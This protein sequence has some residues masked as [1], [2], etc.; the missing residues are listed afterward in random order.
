VILRDAA[1]IRREGD[2]LTGYDVGQ[3]QTYPS[4][5]HQEEEKGLPGIDP[6]LAGRE[7]ISP[8]GGEPPGRPAAG[9]SR[10]RKAGR[11]RKKRSHAGWRRP[12]VLVGIFAG[13]SS[14]LA[15]ALLAAAPGTGTNSHIDQHA[16]ALPS[17]VSVIP[18]SYAIATVP[19]PA[20]TASAPATG[21]PAT[22]APVATTPL[23][24]RSSPSD[25][26]PSHSGP[27]TAG[28]SKANCV[29]AEFPG[30]VLSQSVLDGIT[31]STG[32]TYNCLDTF[33]NPMPT[34][35]DWEAPW[36]FSTVSDGWD[37]WLAASPEHQAIMSM[38]LI[39]QA[40]SN[41]DDPLTW[42]QACASGD[43]NQYATILAKNLVSY[44]A[45]NI[46][47]RL[48]T[49]ANGSWEADYVG[50]T[51]S[52]MSDWAKC[53][54]NEVTAMRAVAG[55]HLLFVW[56][57]NICTADIPISKWYPGNSYVDIIG[58][59]AYDTDCG[60]LKSVAQEGWKAYS[61]DSSSGGSSDPDFPSL[62]NMEAFAAANGKPLSFPEWGLATG[63]DDP[64]YVT[65]MARM[66]EANDFSFE[67]Y[68]NSNDD[69]IAPLGSS[70]PK[71]VAAYTQAFK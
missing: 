7:P 14:A 57:P 35:S 31:S 62:A 67:S 54:A 44:G 50:T 6:E 8:N 24:S 4:R 51:S 18:Q 39:P 71:A 49:E 9:A 59:D 12:L 37:A 19:A 45:G 16:A 29:T 52:E 23:N 34:W 60:T 3:E 53:Y 20:V 38:D 64:A 21:K 33:A 66:F 36:M 25:S 40:V 68:F 27:I 32:V 22:K 63:D 2:L 43:Y 41:V 28:N 30:G 65:A 70:I 11:R 48:G 42:E 46:V 1:V 47:I 26:T 13:I 56:N 55:T 10:A 15:V 58:A 17:A 5:V 69:G 61:T